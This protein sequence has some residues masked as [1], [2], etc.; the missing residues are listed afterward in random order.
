MTP[1]RI[2]RAGAALVLDRTGRRR[3][4]GTVRCVTNLTV[5][6]W[7]EDGAGG[8]QHVRRERLHNMTVDA[9]LN[10]IRDFLNG[11]APTDLTHFAVGTGST[12]AAAGD[13]TLG[14]EVFRAAVT[15]RTKTSKQLTV[16]YYLPSGSANGNTLAEAGLFNH[17]SAGTMFARAVLASTI[18]KTASVAVTFTWELTFAAA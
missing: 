13:T 3:A 18:A 11:D 12:A 16:K 7:H 4:A 2:L 1:V 9:G 8:R 5:D 10:L 15:Q 14:T 17:V 6:V